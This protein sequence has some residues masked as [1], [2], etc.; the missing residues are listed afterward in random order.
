MCYEKH[1]RIVCEPTARTAGGIQGRVRQVLYCF[2][3]FVANRGAT[4]LTGQRDSYF[5]CGAGQP[6]R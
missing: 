3:R 2:Y 4:D 1:Q 6:V 5:D